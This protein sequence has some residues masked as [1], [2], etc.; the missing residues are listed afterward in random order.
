MIKPLATTAKEG[1][2]K[3]KQE[4]AKNRANIDVNVSIDEKAIER[5]I[6]AT[7]KKIVGKLNRK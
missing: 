2:F 3:Q 4:D 1:Y 7:M 5:Q 6:D